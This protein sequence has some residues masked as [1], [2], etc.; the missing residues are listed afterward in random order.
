M[1]VPGQV[2]LI[3]NFLIL[4]QLPEW[5]FGMRWLDGYPA[6]IAPW[7][8]SVFSI[9]LLRQ[10]FLNVPDELWD[11]AQIDG[12]GRFAYLWRVMVPLSR[13]ALVTAGIFIFLG[14]WNSLLWPLICTTSP[15]MRTLMVGLQ[16]LNE[17]M[18]GDSH[19]LMAASTNAIMPVVI[20]FFFLQRF[21]VAGIARAGIQ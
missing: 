5:T 12:A 18:R 4:A 20:L 11:A 2:L 7:L 16:T 13:P 9:F 21:F 8:A 15:H 1:M 3:P 6:L 10:F 19:L 14:Q 17:E